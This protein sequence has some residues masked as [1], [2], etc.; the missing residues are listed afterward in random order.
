MPIYP[1]KCIN[2]HA[3]DRYASVSDRNIASPV[4]RVCGHTMGPVIQG[5]QA[6]LYFE[7]GRGRWINHLTDKPLLVRSHAEHK[8]LMKKYGVELAGNRPGTKGAWR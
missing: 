4:C 8:K 7:E 1:N 5:T 6:L 2:N 3:E